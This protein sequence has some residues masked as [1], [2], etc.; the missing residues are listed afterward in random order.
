MATARMRPE[1]GEVRGDGEK[2][3]NDSG[4]SIAG[5][6]DREEQWCRAIPGR[7]AVLILYARPGRTGSKR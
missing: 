7:H 1:Y 4:R 5:E 3:I 2:D 6:A